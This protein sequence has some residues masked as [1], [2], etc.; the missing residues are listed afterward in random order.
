MRDQ[1][2]KI[3]VDAHPVMHDA[4]NTALCLLADA[5]DEINERTVS[6]EGIVQ[7]AISEE[8]AQSHVDASPVEN[9]PLSGEGRG[10]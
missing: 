10:A 2:N 3:I 1:I 4:V 8:G 5:V 7:D 9:P 6:G